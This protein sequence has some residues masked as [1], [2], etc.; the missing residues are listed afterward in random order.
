VRKLERSD[1]PQDPRAHELLAKR[2][3]RLRAD[4]GQPRGGY[5]RRL[6]EHRDGAREPDRLLAQARECRANRSRDRVR[7]EARHRLRVGLVGTTDAAFAQP[8]RQPV[9]QQRVAA[10][11][12]VARLG[13]GCRDRRA[14]VLGD[15]GCRRVR[16][17]R[18]ELDRRRERGSAQGATGRR[19][20][21]SL[22]DQQQHRDGVE[23]VREE[24][25]EPDRGGVGPVQIV[26][27]QQLGPP[28]RQCRHE[29]V[30]T[31]QDAEGRVGVAG[32][33][34][35]AGPHDRRRQGGG[36]G[37]GPAALPAGHTT[38]PR[39]QQ[40]PDDPPGVRALQL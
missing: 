19:G 3:S 4:A 26:D 40:L 22:S 1:V 34:D 28:R 31:V 14:T 30:Q 38:K 21:R 2:R 8:L 39:L 20:S 37:Q 36:S 32:R 24:L 18:R 27:D 6:L 17:Q 29:P 9:D 23:A 33:R 25:H 13:E 15:H 10:R 7:P 5:E 35:A 12:A 16:R 11:G